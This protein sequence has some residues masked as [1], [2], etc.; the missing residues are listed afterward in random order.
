[1]PT[2][3][4]TISVDESTKKEFDVFCE[5]VGLNA[6]SAVNMFM[7]SVIH[8]KSLPFTISDISAD[9][10][11]VK[12]KNSIQALREQSVA[13]NTDNITMDEINAEIAAYRQEKRSRNA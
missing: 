4:L 8:T 9:D 13:N 1:M 11:T 2:T 7:K 10:I 6:A 3:N 12:L 5:N